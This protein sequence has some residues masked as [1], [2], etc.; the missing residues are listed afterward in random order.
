[1]DVFEKGPNVIGSFQ[2]VI[3][4]KGMLKDIQYQNGCAAG[5]VADVVFIDPKIDEP[6]YE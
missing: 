5:R 4:H 1:V 3:D 6:S 2:P